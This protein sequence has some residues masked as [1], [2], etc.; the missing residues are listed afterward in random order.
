[1][2]GIF[3]KETPT[4]TPEPVEEKVT[5]S[6]NE[7]I[8]IA[9]LQSLK[10][11]LRRQSAQMIADIAH[12]L[13]ERA[14]LMTEIQKA[15]P[16]QKTALAIRVTNIDKTVAGL[17][18]TLALIESQIGNI[19]AKVLQLRT[20]KVIDTGDSESVV[21]SS[22]IHAKLKIATE[23]KTAGDINAGIAEGMFAELTGG[24]TSLSGDVAAILAE[25]E[26]TNQTVSYESGAIQNPDAARSPGPTH[27]IQL[28]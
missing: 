7:L 14:K 28:W 23:K 19:D 25:A 2:F 20:T 18:G 3:K 5:D 12:N 6:N 24:V 17:N 15:P 11:E 27:S 4:Q 1:M 10:A 26:G 8:Q 21:K 16:A 22:D 13:E 9:E